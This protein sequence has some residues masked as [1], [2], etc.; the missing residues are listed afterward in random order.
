M[1]IKLAQRD[2]FSRNGVLLFAKGQEMTDGIMEKLRRLDIVERDDYHPLNNDNL[3]P[4]CKE[5]LSVRFDRLDTAVIKK[6]SDMVSSVIFKSRKNSWKTL[7]N[8][9]ANYVD[10]LYIHSVDVALV[11][12]ILA[13]KMG[14]GKKEQIDFCLSA[15]LH[16]IGK[17]LVPKKIIQKP[18]PL[19]PYEC[20]IMQQHCELGFDVIKDYELPELCGDIVLT[21]HERM[22][23]SGYPAHLKTDDLSEYTK[24]IMVADILDAMTSY[25]PYKPVSTISDAI[26]ELRI[27]KRK[28]DQTIVDFLVNL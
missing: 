17:L 15:L 12:V 19:T 2:I 13:D 1:S 8:A 6:A 28:Y 24:I 23:G 25:R 9:L 5:F 22:D 26:R 16:D 18:G 21:H 20:H 3:A 27:K 7:L 14:Y 4:Y 10:W 11:S